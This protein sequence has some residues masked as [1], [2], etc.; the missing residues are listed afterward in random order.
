M[1]INT[2]H[3]IIILHGLLTFSYA[4][5]Y[6]FSNVGRLTMSPICDQFTTLSTHRKH[7][8]K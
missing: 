5:M 6:N 7:I 2:Q 3:D 4:C 1:G 8:F